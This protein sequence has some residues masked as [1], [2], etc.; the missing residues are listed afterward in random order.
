MGTSQLCEA[1]CAQPNQRPRRNPTPECQ[2]QHRTSAPE[3]IC[4]AR[5]DSRA[6]QIMANSRSPGAANEAKP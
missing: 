4:V 1:L 6:S 5:K 2:E 3:F